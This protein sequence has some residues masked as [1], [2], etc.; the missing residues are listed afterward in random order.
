M[1]RNVLQEFLTI[2]GMA[3]GPN[4]STD[5][6]EPDL[7][8]IQGHPQDDAPM[9]SLRTR[10]NV[11]VAE[12]RKLIGRHQERV[13][14]FLVHRAGPFGG[15][16]RADRRALVR[17]FLATGSYTR[18]ADE[19]GVGRERIR[20]LMH[21]AMR[22]LRSIG[23]APPLTDRAGLKPVA[24]ERSTSHRET[25]ATRRG[26]TNVEGFQNHTSDPN[27]AQLVEAR[28]EARLRPLSA[29]MKRR[30]ETQM[31]D[32]AAR[33][34]GVELYFDDVAKAKQ[35]YTETLGLRVSDEERNRYAKFETGTSFVCLE[36]KGSES[37]PSAD[38]AV[39]F[40]EVHDLEATVASIGRERFVRIESRWAVLHDPEGHSVLLLE[41]GSPH[42]PS[43]LS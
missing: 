41:S 13:V 24:H 38:K 16:L 29:N 5:F 9:K 2:D 4:G 34:V 31:G 17:T 28:S 26:H 14:N 30:M 10:T 15:R 33:L 39:L 43:S 37:Y 40:F 22:H 25:A 21:A 12:T 27:A 42:T 6:V 36:R 19:C 32:L 20:Q 18:P 11:S 23:N 1:R 8:F 3:A 7:P 35:F